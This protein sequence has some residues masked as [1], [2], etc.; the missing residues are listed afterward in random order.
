MTMHTGVQNVK[1]SYLH[2]MR[3]LTKGPWKPR[4][5]LYFSALGDG[6]GAATFESEG[7]TVFTR[8]AQRGYTDARYYWVAGFTDY[9]LGSTIPYSAYYTTSSSKY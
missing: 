6:W 4:P 5:I 3:K 7:E 1:A 8:E 2:V 9:E